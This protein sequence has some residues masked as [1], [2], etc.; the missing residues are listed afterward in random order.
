MTGKKLAEVGIVG[1]LLAAAVGCSANSAKVVTAQSASASQTAAVTSPSTTPTTPTT[2]AST[3][4]ATVPLPP[5]VVLPAGVIDP[6]NLPPADPM[7]VAAINAGPNSRF[8]V[9]YLATIDQA[10]RTRDAA[11]LDHL[12]GCQQSGKCATYDELWSTVGVVDQIPVLLEKAI[13]GQNSGNIYVPQFNGPDMF[14]P[15]KD[16]EEKKLLGVAFPSEYRGLGLHF[17][18]GGLGSTGLNLTWDSASLQAAPSSTVR[19]AA[20]NTVTTAN[21]PK[22]DPAILAKIQT[23]MDSGKPL[24]LPGNLVALVVEAAQDHDIDALLKL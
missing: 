5:K 3:P 21:M 17:Q 11:A 13:L 2:P 22:A 18:A 9:N 24:A 1:A 15:T 8:P 7:I 14:A 16:M 19:L 23:T 10:A 12:V 4:T 6:T 20:L